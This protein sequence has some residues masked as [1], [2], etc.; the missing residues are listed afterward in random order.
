MALL[1]S[2]SRR[3]DGS[4][5]PVIPV[6][7]KYKSRTIDAMALL[8]TGADITFIPEDIAGLLGVKYYRGRES[9]ITGIDKELKCTTHRVDVTFFDGSEKVTV[10][11]VQADVPK[12]SQKKV[13]ILLGR[14]GLLDKFEIRMNEKEDSISLEYLE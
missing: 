10:E 3:S 11:K 14:K 8:D 1:F 7:L 12:I 9:M 4:L 13:G 6:T 5:A 2:Y